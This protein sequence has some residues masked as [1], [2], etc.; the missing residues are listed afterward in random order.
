MRLFHFTSAHHWPLIEQAG[1]LKTVESNVDMLRS[2]AGPDVVWLLDTPTVDLPHGLVMPGYPIDKTQVRFT[3]EVPKPIRW[4]EWG[5]TQSMDPEWRETFLNAAG[6]DEAAEHWW[7]VPARIPAKRWVEVRDMS[8][9]E[10]LWTPQAM[11]MVR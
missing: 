6:G 11:E 2:H 3:V 5:P 8:T 9:D 1:F 7:V 4:S 10:V